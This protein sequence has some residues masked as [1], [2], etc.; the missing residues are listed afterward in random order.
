M[1][2]I[3]DNSQTELRLLADISHYCRKAHEANGSYVGTVHAVADFLMRQFRFSYEDATSFVKTSGFFNEQ[4]TDEVVYDKAAL[5]PL[6]LTDDLI[7][8]QAMLQISFNS[9]DQTEFLHCWYS[10]L[11]SNALGIAG[12]NGHSIEDCCADSATNSPWY[13]DAACVTS[14]R[15]VFRITRQFLLE[16][17][18]QP[19]LT[20]ISD[21]VD[22]LVQH[23]VVESKLSAA[24]DC[25]FITAEEKH[26]LD[27][28]YTECV[29]T[30][31]GQ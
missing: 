20:V 14:D 3:P 13:D 22:E 25:E 27:A 2:Q 15:C 6:L 4:D 7:E 1:E 24:V 28:T 10:N 23:I 19:D 30:R 26:V 11:A 31:G 8:M 5:A 29:A 21:E 12:P 9:G 17:A 16:P 18:M